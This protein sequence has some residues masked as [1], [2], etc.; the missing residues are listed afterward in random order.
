MKIP[1]VENF[2]FC[3]ALESGANVL[4]WICGV[5]AVLALLVYGAG[6]GLAAFNYDALV[7]ATAPNSET[8]Q[9]MMHHLQFGENQLF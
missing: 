7:N 5:F 9:E 6:F 8:H 1:T 2:L 3:W 4:G